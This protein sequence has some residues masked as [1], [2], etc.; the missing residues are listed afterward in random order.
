MLY[1]MEL[2]MRQRRNGWT[3]VEVLVVIGIITLLLQLLLPAIHSVRSSARLM[4]CKRNLKQ[5]GRAATMHHDSLQHLPTGG[6]HYTWI[7]VPER[8]ADVTQPGGWAYNLLDYLDESAVR[9]MG[10]HLTGLELAEA[11][12]DRCSISP[13][14]FVCPARRAATA[15][16]QTWNQFPFTS[17][18]RLSVALSIAKPPTSHVCSGSPTSGMAPN[19]LVITFAPQRLIWPHGSR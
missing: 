5:L 16:P 19:R 11:L 12:R 13:P 6:W 3:L 15:Y 1:E 17:E 18:G 2:R 9:S 14:S 8:G 4:S 7:G 10:S